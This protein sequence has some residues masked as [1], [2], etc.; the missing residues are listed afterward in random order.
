MKHNAPKFTQGI[1]LVTVL[2]LLVVT[3]TIVTTGSLLALG[4]RRS[5]TE[6]LNTIKAQYAAESGIEKTLNE[7]F[8]TTKSNFDSLK[9]PIAGGHAVDAPFDACAFKLL[10]TGIVGI[11]STATAGKNDNQNG[12]LLCSYDWSTSIAKPKAVFLNLYSNATLLA[13]KT[14]ATGAN[15][16]YSV[17]ISRRDSTDGEDITFDFVSIGT[18]KDANGKEIAVRVLKKSVT[19]SGTPYTGDKFAMLTTASDCSFCHTHIDTM[20][21]AYSIGAGSADRVLVG[22]LSD[23]TVS[24]F[25][26]FLC[27][28]FHNDTVVAGTIYVR[29]KSINDCNAKRFLSLKWKDTANPGKV[30]FGTTDNAKGYLMGASGTS[31]TDPVDARIIDAIA[32]PAQAYGKIYSNYPDTNSVAAAPFKG[33]FPDEKLPVNF[34]SVVTDNGDTLI[35]DVEW[36]DYV[37][38]A[39]SGKLT[40]GIV[41]GVQRPGSDSTKIAAT[42]PISYDPVLAN[43]LP[44]TVTAASLPAFLQTLDALNASPANTTAKNNLVANY[45][46][47]L[48][49]QAIASPNNRDFFPTNPTTYSSVA[50]TTSY[51]SRAFVP[52]TTVAAIAQ[53]GG[54]VQVA[55][56]PARVFGNASNTVLVEF[57]N[58]A[59]AATVAPITGYLRANAAA[60]NLA[61]IINVTGLSGNVGA[62]WNVRIYVRWF[63]PISW[64]DQSRNGQLVSTDPLAPNAPN[65]TGAIENNFWVKFVKGATPSVSLTYCTAVPCT[66]A[67]LTFISIP[68]NASIAGVT[69][70]IFFP[71]AS[72]NAA[73]DL[74]GTNATHQS[75]YY[76]GNLIL[77]GGRL[78]NSSNQVIDIDG[79]ILINGDLVIRGQVTGTG[80]VIAR[81][82]IYVVGDLSYYCKGATSATDHACTNA[83]YAD[84]LAR[85]LP[86]LALMA[87]GGIFIG[88]S[89]ISRADNITGSDLDASSLDL[90]NDQTLQSSA[91]KPDNSKNF[92]YFNIPGGSGGQGTAGFLTELL[93][94][95]NNRS[96]QRDLATN[97]F[98]FIEVGSSRASAYEQNA[99]FRTT[100]NTKSIIPTVPSNGPVSIGDN[101]KS[102]LFKTP[103]SNQLSNNF[104]CVSSTF[105]NPSDPT[106]PPVS[107]TNNGFTTGIGR[108]DFNFAT[109]CPPTTSTS[110]YV[111]AGIAVPTTPGSTPSTNAN[112]WFQQPTQNKALDGNIGMT[113]GWLGGLLNFDANA[114]VNAF[115]QLGDLSQTRLLKLMWL[116]TIEDGSRDAD[117]STAAVDKGPLHTDGIFYSPQAIFGLVRGRLGG[118]LGANSTS[119]QGRWIHNGSILSYE[120]GFL[121]PG[122]LGN[123]AAQTTQIA[124]MPVSFGPADTSANAKNGPGMGLY[125]DDRLRGL[126]KI[127]AVAGVRI[128]PSGGYTQVA[129]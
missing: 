21:R 42:T 99:A 43:G 27:G 50:S 119:T 81:G 5:S 52:T 96:T 80:R 4:N 46:G 26:L 28:D 66:N 95:M 112:A 57:R 125:Y 121:T 13:A 126:L 109:W 39:A 104:S 24:N 117:P 11:D 84:A 98:G 6:N 68:I 111:R 92:N 110:K 71:S 20:K 94:V 48:L 35:S 115:T 114:S 1:A 123:T 70:N 107:F 97:P 65:G 69:R 73:D 15:P 58:P 77:D 23:P 16:S 31:L 83:D 88:D 100:S 79:T 7:V 122:L 62:N 56:L 86:R 14:S 76:D 101:S 75:G 89:D 82:N 90:I 40:G 25:N 34:P 55:N 113:T 63:V 67:T 30:I 59:N 18:V 64:G 60:S 91:R 85:N 87:S 54:N 37:K 19:I 61:T 51:A 93:P 36:S 108:P 47:W 129:R 106:L 53:P 41:Y 49:Q 103:G 33:T 72:N 78:T 44:G 118:G 2:I 22:V 17:D 124:T 116:S 105:V 127:D 10:L 8:Y 32:S 29:S 9:K 3:V 12:P 45:S 38:N 74:A 128:K 102:G 120:L